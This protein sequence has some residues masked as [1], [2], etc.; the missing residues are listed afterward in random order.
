MRKIIRSEQGQI[1]IMSAIFV[2]VLLLC[3]GLAIDAG[4]LYVTKAKLSTAVDAA[5]LTGM[6]NLSLGQPTATQDATWV[7]DANFGA[8]PPT[9]TITFPTDAYGDLQVKVTATAVVNTTFIRIL[10]WFATVNVSDTA[11]STRGKLVMSLVLDNSQSMSSDGGS[12]ALPPAVIAFVKDFNDSTDEVGMTHF[13]TL[14]TLDYSVQTPFQVAI[15]NAVNAMNFDAGL[16]EDSTTSP[17]GLAMAKTQED[18]VIPQPG[19]NVIKVVVFFTDGMANAV[20]QS[21]PCGGTATTMEFGGVDSSGNPLYFFDV[22]GRY[23]GTYNGN[24]SN[25]YCSGVSTFTAA[26]Y[27]GIQ[28]PITQSNVTVESI[29]DGEQIASAMRAEGI[30]I[31]SIGLGNGISAATKTFL[32]TVAN[33]PAGPNYNSSQPA[34]LFLD[35]PDCPSG[36][37]TTE[38]NIAFQTIASKVLLRLTQ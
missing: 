29:Y 2:P 15:T 12:S 33:D 34:G 3:T 18:S 8:N 14:A 13:S 26:A 35:V 6:K 22:T 31:Y 20:Q 23:L 24:G 28:K 21:L 11:V 9:P 4:L 5:C 27:G 32:Q 19:Q 1:L 7:F 25:P 38:L 10:P 37:C 17:L 16:P 30:F 36:T